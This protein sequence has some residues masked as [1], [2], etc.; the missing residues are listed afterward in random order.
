MA[1]TMLT[2]ITV[3]PMNSVQSGARIASNAAVISHAHANAKVEIIRRA[4]RESLGLAA[5]A[6]SPS[7]TTTLPSAAERPTQDVMAAAS[8]PDPPDIA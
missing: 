5:A 4:C 6:A 1:T 8:P 7:K 2:V 3:P